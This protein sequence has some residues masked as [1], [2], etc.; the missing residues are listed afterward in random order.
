MTQEEKQSLKNRLY[1]AHT[2]GDYKEDDP[3]VGIYFNSLVELM[4][5]YKNG[6]L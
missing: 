1:D 4:D 6:N 3:F 5:D 2:I